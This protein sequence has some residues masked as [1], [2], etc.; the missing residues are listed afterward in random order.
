MKKISLAIIPAL[1][2]LT[3]CQVKIP[4]VISSV[5]DIFTLAKNIDYKKISSAKILS[6]VYD[7]KTN[8]MLRSAMSDRVYDH[9]IKSGVI[10]DTLKILSD[11]SSDKEYD[12]SKEETT[13]KAKPSKFFDLNIEKLLF[14]SK[15][16][17]D[18]FE[19]LNGTFTLSPKSNAQ[20]KINERPMFLTKTSLSFT[21]DLAFKNLHIE[22]QDS[23]FM[24]SH[25]ITLN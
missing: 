4:T 7:V 5:D 22:Y 1:L 14:D 2:I 19:G 8:I 21:G 9:A 11:Y 18:K 24:V 17:E 12:E 15:Y 23:V 10:T 13:L 16:Y 25:T 20:I 6:E 3:G